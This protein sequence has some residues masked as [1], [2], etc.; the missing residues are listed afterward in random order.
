MDI[1]IDVPQKK[2]TELPYCSDTSNLGMQT[3]N[4]YFT[5]ILANP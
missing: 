3:L 1:S 4:Q 2:P 5:D